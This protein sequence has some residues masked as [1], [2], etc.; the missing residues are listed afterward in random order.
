[1]TMS[2]ADNIL[3]IICTSNEKVF[4]KNKVIRTATKRT[5]TS[6]WPPMQCTY[7]PSPLC[8]TT[9]QRGLG[10]YMHCFGGH[11]LVSCSSPSY[12]VFVKNFCIICL[13]SFTLK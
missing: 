13:H 9:A 5:E 4:N 6:V 3:V 10:M 7:I 12:P 11:T 2:E 8:C 1:M